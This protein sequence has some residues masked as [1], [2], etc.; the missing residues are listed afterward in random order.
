[1]KGKKIYLGDSVYATFDGYY[2]ELTTE[3]GYGATNSILLEPQVLDA[4][5]NYLKGLKSKPD[6]SIND[7]LTINNP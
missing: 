3:N 4:L 7:N 1:M 6:T 5:D 2:V